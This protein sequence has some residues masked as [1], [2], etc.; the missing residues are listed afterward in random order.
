MNA[1]LWLRGLAETE[2][3]ANKLPI[4]IF[5]TVTNNSDSCRHEV[6]S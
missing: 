5:P 1:C 4:A 6:Q 2:W 3:V